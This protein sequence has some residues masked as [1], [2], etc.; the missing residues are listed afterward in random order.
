MP[1]FYELKDYILNYLDD[2]VQ[3][4]APFDKLD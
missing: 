2:A 1:L 4:Q 3:Y